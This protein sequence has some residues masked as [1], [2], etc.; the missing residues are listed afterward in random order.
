MPKAEKTT[1]LNSVATRLWLLRTT[2]VRRQTVLFE[3]F[4]QALP[5]HIRLSGRAGDVAVILFE[6]RNQIVLLG[7]FQSLR[8]R[9]PLRLRIRRRRD[10]EC[11]PPQSG[12]QVRGND[13]ILPRDGQ[14]VLDGVAQL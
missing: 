5:R 8:A 4:M 11:R 14:R 7:V 13:R 10:G 1:M 6:E 3:K 2:F 12:G 9:Q